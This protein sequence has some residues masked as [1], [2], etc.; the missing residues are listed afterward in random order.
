MV[1]NKLR[2]DREYDD[3]KRRHRDEQQRLVELKNRETLERLT[4]AKKKE[5]EGAGMRKTSFTAY[6]SIDDMP[7]A[8]ELQVRASLSR[9]LFIIYMY[10]IKKKIVIYFRCLSLEFFC[11]RQVF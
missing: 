10:T 9:S 7:K 1:D 11:R 2:S 4:N 5:G 6:Q 8:R 3:D